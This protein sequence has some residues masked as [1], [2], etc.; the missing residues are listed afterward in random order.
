MS[1][2]MNHQMTPRRS[3]AGWLLVGAGLLA[4]A[5]NLGWLAT[6]P[7]VLLGVVSLLLGGAALAAFGLK[8]QERWWALIPASA[9]IGSGLA[10]ATPAAWSGLA[11]L[12]MLGM[13]FLV[14]ATR[15]KDLWWALIPGGTLLGLALVTVDPGEAGASWLF[16]GIALGFVLVALGSSQRRWAFIPAAGL[17]I[18]W[19]AV[20]GNLAPVLAS[21]WPLALIA[22]GGILLLWR[23]SKR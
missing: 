18:P 6:A 22:V 17:L 7:N 3:W 20:M 23:S 11:L 12:G 15:R 9:L 1:S 2:L 21:L 4:L 14:I 5:A 19:L 8:V 10:A 13:G 16:L